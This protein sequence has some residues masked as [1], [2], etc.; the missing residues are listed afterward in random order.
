MPEVVCALGAGVRRGTAACCGTPGSSPRGPTGPRSA[1]ASSRRHR[2][3]PDQRLPG[4]DRGALGDQHLAAPRRRAGR[5]ARSA[6]SSPRRPPPTGPAPRARP[7]S[8]G[9]A[10][11]SPGIGAVMVSPPPAPAGAPRRLHELLERMPDLDRDGRPVAR[12]LDAVRGRAP[13]APRTSGRPRAASTPRRPGGDGS[14]PRAACPPRRA[15]AGSPSARNSTSSS[16][17]SSVTQSFIAAP[18]R[19]RAGVRPIA[20]PTGGRRWPRAAS[21]AAGPRGRAVR[22]PAA[23]RGVLAPGRQRLGVK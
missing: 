5:P 18:A 13:R 14:R 23:P 4:A 3:E 20:R 15:T 8:R 12:H 9:C 6:S 17:P 21:R 22:R 7:P 2:R 1:A 16:R 11:T 10:T 19:P